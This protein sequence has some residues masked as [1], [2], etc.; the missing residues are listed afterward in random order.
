M[1]LKV[2]ADDEAQLCSCYSFSGLKHLMIQ[3]L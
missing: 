2:D 1:K 3:S